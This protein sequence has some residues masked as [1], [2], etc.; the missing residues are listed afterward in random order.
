MDAWNSVI[1]NDMKNLKQRYAGKAAKQKRRFV[2]DVIMYIFFYCI[3]FFMAYYYL[4]RKFPDLHPVLLLGLCG[5]TA[6]V[7]TIMGA[8]GVQF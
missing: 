3:F 2:I 4:S 6:L 8:T 5:V 7:F 1:L